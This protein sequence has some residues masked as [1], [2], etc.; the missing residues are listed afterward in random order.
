MAIWLSRFRPARS[1]A[2]RFNKGLTV[3]GQTYKH[4]LPL[5]ANATYLLRSIN[6]GVSDKLVAFQVVRQEPDS[7]VIIAWKILKSFPTPEL[8]RNK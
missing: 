5:Q 6:Y 7:S 1:E 2:S 8:V 4:S 3:E